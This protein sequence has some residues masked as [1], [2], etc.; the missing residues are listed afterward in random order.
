M[1]TAPSPTSWMAGLVRPD[2]PAA[3]TPSDQQ[4]EPPITM[5]PARRL[6]LGGLVVDEGGHGGDAHGPAGRADGRHHRDPDADDQGGD[7]GAGLEDE[8]ARRAG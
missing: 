1:A 2:A 3:T 6:G 5:P 8:G 7:H 4:I